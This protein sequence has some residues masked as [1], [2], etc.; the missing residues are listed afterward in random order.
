[1]RAATCAAVKPEI[2]RPHDFALA[3]R[4]AAD[5]LGEIFAEP[6]ADQMLLDFAEVA[7]ADHALGI[8]GELAHRLDIGGEPG[9]PVGRALLAVEQ[10][11]DGVPSTTTRSRTLAMASASKASSAAVASR[12]SSTSS[13]SAVEER[14]AAMGMR[15]SGTGVRRRSAGGS[16]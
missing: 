14:E 10:A 15:P 12:L 3:H 7:V 2:A 6:D 1:M 8:G 11:A 4:N 16:Y 5:D 13:C 9:Q